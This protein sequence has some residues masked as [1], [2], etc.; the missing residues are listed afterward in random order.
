MKETDFATAS[1]HLNQVLG[2]DLDKHLNFT[3]ASTLKAFSVIGSLVV[4]YRYAEALGKTLVVHDMTVG[5]HQSHLLGTELDFDLSSPRKDPITQ[6]NIASDL[7]RIREELRT[8]LDAFRVGIYFDFF[9]NT[10][11]ETFADFQQLYGDAKTAVSMHLGVRY[12]WSSPEYQGNPMT[13]ATGAFVVW[14][15][16]SKGYGNSDLWARRI[17]SWKI[18]FLKEQS[19]P[20]ARNTIA[21]D[22]RALD[23]NPPRL[24]A[25]EPLPD[26]L[27][28]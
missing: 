18:G 15:K 8:E 27:W 11:A 16:G 6:V 21:T 4:V 1:T 2:I 17:R 9:S 20:L 7:L 19:E 23:N 14:G 12:R 3:R 13:S 24:Q 10:E 28:A 25:E 5:G 22:F 26:T